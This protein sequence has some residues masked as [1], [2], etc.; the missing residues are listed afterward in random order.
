MSSENGET[1]KLGRPAGVRNKATLRKLRDVERSG[2]MPLDYML[3]VMRDTKADRARRDDMA[4]A[5]APYIH[6]KLATLQSD[7]KLTGR[8]TLEQLVLASVPSETEAAQG[9]D[10]KPE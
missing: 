10:E 2:L 7:V 5:A 9:E 8:L 4:K 6:P 1:K 3:K